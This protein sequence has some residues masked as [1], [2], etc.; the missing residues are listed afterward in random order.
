MLAL[1]H[2]PTGDLEV[3]CPQTGLFLSLTFAK[4]HSVKGTL[5][6]LTPTQPPPSLAP[7]AATDSSSTSSG[8]SSG[9]GGGLA[10]SSSKVKA[11]GA[12]A[13]AQFVGSLEGSWMGSI[14]ITCP[15]L[16]CLQTFDTAF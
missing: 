10:G 15:L 3:S 14:K 13:K 16:V 11:G 1:L 5:E 9:G 8:S 7:A 6:Q 4:D 12:P 2:C